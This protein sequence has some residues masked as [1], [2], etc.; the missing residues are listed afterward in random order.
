MEELKEFGLSENEI[1]IYLTLLKTGSSTANRI[2]QITGLKRSTTYDNLSFLVNKGVVSTI[3]KDNVNY[4]E[5]A[6]PKKLIYLLEEKKERIQK[7]IPGLLKIKESISEKTGVT[8]FEGKKGVL[9][10]LNDIIEQK[11]ELWFY[12]SRKMA[13]LALKHYPENFIQK[14]AERG[15][16]LRALLAA[17]DRG[18]PT[19]LDKKIFKLSNLKF[20]KG[21]NDITTNVFIYGDRV[22]LMTSS[23]NPVGIII[24]NKEIINQQKIL[25]EI[26]WKTAKE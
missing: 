13:L 23:E 1:T 24:R 4:F 11:R 10:V 7:I 14:R 22:A 20:L 6:D 25:F 21:L 15:I 9:T 3:N 16:E 17:Q 19:Y 26:L 8:Y 5:A 18:D 2:S 12:G